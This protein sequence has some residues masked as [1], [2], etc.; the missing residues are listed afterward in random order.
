[1]VCD[2]QDG[3]GDSDGVRR[4]HRR[5]VYRSRDGAPSMG[6]GEETGAFRDL[7]EVSYAYPSSVPYP[8]LTREQAVEGVV[9][10]GG[11]GALYFAVV[12]REAV[13]VR[14][15]EEEVGREEE[16]HEDDRGI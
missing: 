11:G 16:E 4:R 5:G 13:D 9:D 12:V 15:E 2:G 6:A 14:R 8:H 3:D 10:G 1:M 7:D